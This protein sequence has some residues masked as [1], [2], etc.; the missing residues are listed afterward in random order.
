MLDM[1]AVERIDGRERVEGTTPLGPGFAD[2]ARR[3]TWT[4]W[5]D[6]WKVIS[7]PQA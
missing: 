6:R 4:E 1:A 2:L 3:V 7:E 5:V